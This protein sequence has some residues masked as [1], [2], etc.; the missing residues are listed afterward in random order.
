MSINEKTPSRLC[1][2]FLDLIS[3]ANH[4]KRGIS[5]NHEIL[6]PLIVSLV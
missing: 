4:E 5:G 3:S 1:N 2:P 6:K